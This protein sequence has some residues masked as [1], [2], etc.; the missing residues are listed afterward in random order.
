M[1]LSD[2][3]IAL[4]FRRATDKLRGDSPCEVDEFQSTKH[5]G[6]GT[7]PTVQ[8]GQDPHT[9]RGRFQLLVKSLKNSGSEVVLETH[10]DD[11]S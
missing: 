11:K 4:R 2:A 3:A 10:Q 6:M 5:C 9:G 7:Q 1:T 8:E